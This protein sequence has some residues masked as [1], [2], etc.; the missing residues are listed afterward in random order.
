MRSA[1]NDYCP[2]HLWEAAL[3]VRMSFIRILHVL[4]QLQVLVN[5]NLLA[6]NIDHPGAS[7]GTCRRGRPAPP[8]CILPSYFGQFE[9]LRQPVQL[10]AH[11]VPLTLH[12][13]IQPPR[14]HGP[15]DVPAR[16]IAL[17][18]KLRVLGGSC[19]RFHASLTLSIART[20]RSASTFS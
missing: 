11:G 1:H 19:S 18:T 2:I 20:R 3:R 10:P 13:G 14:D 9:G 12:I 7:P 17:F 5:V 8:A 15:V 4:S 6:A 16:R